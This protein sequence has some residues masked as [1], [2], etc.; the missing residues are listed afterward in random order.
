M[1]KKLKFWSYIQQRAYVSSLVKRKKR[2]MRKEK[3][4]KKEREKKEKDEKRREELPP[5]GSSCESEVSLPDCPWYWISSGRWVTKTYTGAVL[6]LRARGD[7]PSLVFLSTKEASKMQVPQILWNQK[8]VRCLSPLKQ[9]DRYPFYKQISSGSL[10]LPCKDLKG[11]GF[12][13]AGP[14]SAPVLCPT[15]RMTPT[16]DPYPTCH[17]LCKLFVRPHNVLMFLCDCHMH[18][19]RA[20]NPKKLRMKAQ[21]SP[22]ATPKSMFER[23]R[24]K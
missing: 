15:F 24:P 13:N 10:H 5:D 6:Y 8:N 23:L 20:I 2:R 22:A 17:E 18:L 19:K 14:C 7:L 12:E 21:I 9:N 3:R 16:L 11:G 1:K 4:K